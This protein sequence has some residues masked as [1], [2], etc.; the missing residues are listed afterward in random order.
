MDWSPWCDACGFDLVF[1]EECGC[2]IQVATEHKFLD[3]VWHVF[4]RTSSL[5]ILLDGV[6]LD[7]TVDKDFTFRRVRDGHELKSLNAL[8]WMY[9]VYTYDD[10]RRQK[11]R[12]ELTRERVRKI[13]LCD[14]H[15]RC[16][17][18]THTGDIHWQASLQSV[19]AYIWDVYD[20][21]IPD[22][23]SPVRLR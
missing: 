17:C 9:I 11:A 4:K 15:E 1:G 7:R 12:I 2:A 14:K 19:Y 5:P 20:A 23:A 6:P 16:V 22:V 18:E 8:V 3:M 10:E 13:I 21:Q